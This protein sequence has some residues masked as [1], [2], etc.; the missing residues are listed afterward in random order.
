MVIGI[1]AFNIKSGGGIKQLDYLIEALLQ[2]KNFTRIFLVSN[3]KILNRYKNELIIEY[4]F[5]NIFYIIPNFIKIDNFF[6]KNKCVLIL[7]PGGINI[8]SFGPFISISQN[9]LPFENEEIN[10]FSFISRLKFKILKHLQLKTFNN[11]AGI[12]FLHD[13]AKEKILKILNKHVNNTIIPH[14]IESTENLY[15]KNRNLNK[16]NFNLLYVSDFFP[17]KNH[18]TLIEAILYL[19]ENGTDVSLEIIGR[20]LGQKKYYDESFKNRFCYNQ[21]IKFNGFVKHSDQIEIYKK[22]DLFVFP[23]GCE[24]LPFIMLEAMS[25]G[26]PIVT[27]NKGPMN[28]IVKGENIYFNQNDF[29]DIANIIKLN[30]LDYK[31]LEK[32]SRSNFNRT[33]NYNFDNYVLQTNNFINKTIKNVNI[34]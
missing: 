4:Y 12:I 17:Y 27:S 8:G 16:S 20:D 11:S 15:L 29:I 14:P 26:M 30:L 3:E 18:K 6:K 9:M 24:N 13:Y 34:R 19:N 21:K 2:N 1:N 28:Q 23:S 22:I 5:K 33:K 31:V 32:N 7:L 25:F 10:K